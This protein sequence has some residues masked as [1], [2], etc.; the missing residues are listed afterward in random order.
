MRSGYCY[1]CDEPAAA[2]PCPTCGKVLHRPST[3]S[4]A[5]PAERPPTLVAA[6]GSDDSRPFASWVK[7]IVGIVVLIVI[8]FLL[9]SPFGI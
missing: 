3:D 8:G 4:P 6:G 9:R 7:W 5:A 1:F 2:D